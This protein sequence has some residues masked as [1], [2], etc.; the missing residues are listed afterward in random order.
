MVAYRG[1][2][3]P[4]RIRLGN[5]Y[6]RGC[7]PHAFHLRL[8]NALKGHGFQILPL[9]FIV[10]NIDEKRGFTG[11]GRPVNTTSL[12]LGMSSEIFFRLP[13]AAP[14]ILISDICSSL[15]VEDFQKCCILKL[16]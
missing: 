7:A 6:C 16:L 11:T 9:A 3:I 13:S 14:I 2:G 10:E 8:M 5:H 15:V 4:V 1:T 12:F